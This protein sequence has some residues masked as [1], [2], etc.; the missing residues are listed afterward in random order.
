MSPTWIDPHLELNGS[1]VRLVPLELSHVPAL[2]RAGNDPEIWRYVPI[3]M[4]SQDDMEDYVKGALDSRVR[5]EAFPFAIT[6]AATGSVVGST[7]YYA[8]TQGHRN[9]EIGY[10]WL[11]RSR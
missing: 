1:Y 2:F 6:D 8:L 9:L 3:K 10:T 11:E 7:R 4:K 5:G